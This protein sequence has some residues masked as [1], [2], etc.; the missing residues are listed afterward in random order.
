M[1]RWNDGYG[2]DCGRSRGGPGR[3]A[4]R[5]TEASKAAVR[6]VRSNVDSGRPLRRFVETLRN[7]CSGRGSRPMAVRELPLSLNTALSGVAE[8]ASN[9]LRLC[10]K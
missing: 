7:A 6:Y 1:A 8:K 9:L 4:I 5:P 3:G 2:T 10:E